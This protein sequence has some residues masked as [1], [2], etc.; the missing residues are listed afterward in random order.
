MFGSVGGWAEAE[1]VLMAFCVAVPT[2]IRWVLL[3]RGLDVMPF[4]GHCCPEF[5]PLGLVP[6]CRRSA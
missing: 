1:A 4:M 6:P 3:V 2:G 5:W